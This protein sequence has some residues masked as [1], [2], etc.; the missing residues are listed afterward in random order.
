MI[1][2]GEEVRIVDNATKEDITKVTLGAHHLR[3]GEVQLRANCRIVGAAG[4]H[5]VRRGVRPAAAIAHQRSLRTSC[6]RRA[7]V[8]GE[9]ANR[10]CAILWSPP[11]APSTRCSGA[12]MSACATRWTSSHTSRRCA[13]RLASSRPAS[14]S[15]EAHALARLERRTRAPLQGSG[16]RLGPSTRPI[17]AMCPRRELRQAVALRR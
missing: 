8:V 11:S 1:K 6:K 15:L 14:T 12:W 4:H 5:P 13:G 16:P 9:G 10:R 17:T 7:E 2:D 3:A